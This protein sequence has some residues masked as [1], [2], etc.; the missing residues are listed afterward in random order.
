MERFTRVHP[1]RVLVIA[2]GHAAPVFE[3]IGAPF[4]GVAR[5]VPFRVV[6]LGAGPE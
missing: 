4:P 2:G 1:V 5:L 3:P 6:G